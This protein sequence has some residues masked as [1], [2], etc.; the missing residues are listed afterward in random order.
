MN[1]LLIVLLSGLVIGASAA[2]LGAS[3]DVAL[4]AGSCASLLILLA[5]ITVEE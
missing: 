4:L 5:S 1:G 2:S 3:F